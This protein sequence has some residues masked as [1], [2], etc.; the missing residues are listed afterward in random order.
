[1]R[2]GDWRREIVP[3]HAQMLPP[4][5]VFRPPRLRAQAARVFFL[6]KFYPTVLAYSRSIFKNIACLIIILALAEQYKNIDIVD[7]IYTFWRLSCPF[8]RFIL[9]VPKCEPLPSITRDARRWTC[10]EMAMT[11]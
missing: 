7:C 8:G 1:M 11:S 5:E 3:D 9:V 2:V 6:P 10:S 4:Q